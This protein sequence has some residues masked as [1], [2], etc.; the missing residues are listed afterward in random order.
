METSKIELGSDSASC[1]STNWSL[2]PQGVHRESTSDSKGVQGGRSGVWGWDCED[3]TRNS[4]KGAATVGR[5]QHQQPG[6]ILM[7]TGTF[8]MLL[9]HLTG[10]HGDRRGCAHMHALRCISN[11]LPRLAQRCQQWWAGQ[12]NTQVHTRVEYMVP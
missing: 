1:L 4:P 10:C 5:A 6:R 7:W 3:L 2:L 11:L 12:T 9:S 8:W